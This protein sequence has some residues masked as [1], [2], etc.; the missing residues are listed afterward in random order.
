MFDLFNSL[1]WPCVLHR[2]VTTVYIF[3][4]LKLQPGNER[5]AM[6]CK[7]KHYVSGAIQ[8]TTSAGIFSTQYEMLCVVRGFNNCIFLSVI[9]IY[10][11]AAHKSNT[12]NSV[13][14]KVHYPLCY[15]II[16]MRIYGPEYFEIKKKTHVF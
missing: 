12:K 6:Q 5:C 13:P 15:L 2:I 7:V 3:F 1:C 14:E 4:K 11:S 10:V 8:S 9:F 16:T